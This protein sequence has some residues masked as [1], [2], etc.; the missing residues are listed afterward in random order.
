MTK[1]VEGRCFAEITNI[2]SLLDTPT[3]RE[4]FECCGHIKRIEMVN[5]IDSNDRICIVQFSNSQESEA[6]ALLSGTLL[7]DKPIQV[8][9][10][11]L[12]EV[13][14]NLNKSQ[15]KT[16][17]CESSSTALDV[18]EAARRQVEEWANAPPVPDRSNVKKSEADKRRDEQIAR[19]I[20]V[21]NICPQIKAEHIRSFFTT[22]G[23]IKF[24]KMSGPGMDNPYCFVE[25]VDVAAAERAHSLAGTVLGDR[26]IKVG[27]VKTPI[28]GTTGVASNIL[29][30]PMKLSK[31]MSN[32]RFALEK[33][34]R[35]KKDCSRS[36]R[37]S[38]ERRR[39]RRSRSYSSSRSRSYSRSR[40]RRSRSRRSR[41]RR[42]R[43]RRRYHSRSRSRRSHSRSRGRLRRA[44]SGNRR[45]N[46]NP[47][48]MVWDGFNWHPKESVEGIAT[49]KAVQVAVAGPKSNV[50]YSQGYVNRQ[51]GASSAAYAP[52]GGGAYLG[53]ELAQ[54]ALESFM[55]PTGN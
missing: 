22:Q 36:S 24:V 30:N 48:D 47:K 40:S 2:S 39:R 10:R 34:E 52:P 38:K 14:S 35:K 49:K 15:Q 37:R 16:T 23:D 19:T 11:D 18:V 42:K 6:A 50:G 8:K 33:I 51:S 27:R 46:N 7:G 54:K 26:P 20:Y 32:A 41:S 4:L 12:S 45:S 43:R 44:F 55:Y 53:R 25:F 17:K 1:E 29:N 21:G 3:L 13:E 28:Q 5:D 31:A 9:Q